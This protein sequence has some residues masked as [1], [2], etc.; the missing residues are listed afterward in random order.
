MKKIKK[1][2]ILI[3]LFIVYIV[4][5]IMLFISNEKINTAG[6]NNGKN[7]ILKEEIHGS[8]IGIV[9][10]EINNLGFNIESIEK[11]SN[12]VSADIFID[13][14]NDDIEKSLEGLKNFDC[15][16]ENYTINKNDSICVRIK[17]KIP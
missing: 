3:I 5:G 13:S 7:E 17:V 1:E 6:N 4:Q 15:S 11:E 12:K 16:I 9:L 10:E 2:A 14:L 8:D